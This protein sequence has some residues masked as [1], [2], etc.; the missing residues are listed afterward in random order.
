[1]KKSMTTDERLDRLTGIVDT[2]AASV[3]AHDSQIESLITVA[4]KQGSRIQALITAA[5]KH[6][7]A[8]EDLHKQWQAYLNPLPRQ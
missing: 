8:I 3:V 5:E 7:Q 1:M 6:E 2:L 4:E